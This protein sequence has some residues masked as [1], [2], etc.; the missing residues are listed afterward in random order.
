MPKIDRIVYGIIAI[1]LAI[2]GQN[3]LEKDLLFDAIL[4][5]G[6]G[7]ILLVTPYFWT[8][9]PELSLDLADAEEER[10]LGLPNWSKSWW[11]RLLLLSV[12]A[13][14][15]AACLW[16]LLE[17]NRDFYRPAEHAWPLY[18][19][20]L[21]ILLL[22]AALMD[23]APYALW[24]LTNSY[25]RQPAFYE[26]KSV[27]FTPM[28][29]M[30]R[31]LRLI[32]ALASAVGY[33]LGFWRL[34]IVPPETADRLSDPDDFV[35]VDDNESVRV[36]S[37]PVHN[38]PW[39]KR[40]S[41]FF[42]LTLAVAMFMRLYLL[43]EWP[44]GT[45][46]DEAAAGLMGLRMV[47]DPTWQPV[48]PGSINI[49]A[50]YTYLIAKSVELFGPT[51]TAVRMVSVI[52]GLLA[53]PAAYMAGRELF[54]RSVGLL[55]MF[56]MATSRW[57]VNFSRIGMYNIATP[58]FE[59]LSL[60]YML[61]ALRRNRYLDFAL[62]GLFVGLGLSFYPAFQLF[63]GALGL[64]LLYQ[65]IATRGFLVRYWSG[66]LVMT[67]MAVMVLSPLG[68]FAYQ[69]SDVYF[70][71]TKETSL[72][73]TTQPGERVSALIENTRK[74]LLMF[75][76]RGDPNGRHNL[77][78]KPMMDPYTGALMVLGLIVTLRWFWRPRTFFLLAWLGC[79]LLG[80]ILSLD[81]EAPQ[82][83]RS[84]ATLPAVYLL[85]TLP[86][87]LLWR[88]WTQSVDPYFSNTFVWFSGLL[89]IPVALT[90]G[91]TYFVDQRTDF[92]VWNAYSTPETLTAELLRS[93]DED[94]DAYVI[95][96]F[97]G[98]PTINYLAQTKQQ[99]HRVE[100]TDHLPLDWA[101]GRDALLV[102]NAESRSLYEQARHYYPNAEFEEIKPPF[103]GPTVLYR[104]HLRQSDIESIQGLN[105]FY[106]DNE[107][108]TGT[109]VHTQRDSQ[110]SF[111]WQSEPPLAGP[112]S[113]EWQGVLRV[114]H[115]GP[116]Q[117]FLQAPAEAE[118]YVGEKLI[119]SLNDSEAD[120]RETA[121]ED[122]SDGEDDEQAQ[123]NASGA[124]LTLAEGNHSIRLRV[125]GAPG[126]LNFAWR[127]PDR[128]YELVPSRSLY[129]QP[130]SSNGLLGEYYANG[131]WE[132]APTL[133]RIDA[134][135]E[136][137]FH[138][139]PLPRP[140]TVQWR[141]KI[142]I[143]QAGRYSFG[144]ESIDESVLTID[145]QEVVSAQERNHYVEG[146][147]EL[148]M[149]LHDISIRYADRTD[150][151]H[152]NLH[153][154]QPGGVREIVP[155][156]FLFPPQASYERVALP[157]AG[158][159]RFDP[160]QPNGVSVVTPV[161]PNQPQPMF[162]GFE[163]PVGI[164][165]N[166]DGTLFVS[167]VRNRRVLVYSASG[168]ALDPILGVP[169]SRTANNGE[170][171][172]D[173]E[174]FG[175]PF[176]LAHDSQGRLLVLD[177]GTSQISLFDG[178]GESVGEYISTL[179]I[180]PNL[181]IRS[182]GLHVDQQD[183]VWVPLTPRGRVAAFTLEG[184][185]LI[186]FPV[187]PGENSQPVDVAVSDQGDIWVVDS[188]LHKL[189]RFD[190]EGQRQLAWDIAEAN[191]LHGPHLA[192]DRAGILYMTEPEAE[193]IVKIDPSGERL[194][195]WQL[196]P[197]IEDVAKPI[198]IDIDQN[199]ELWYVDYVNQFAATMG[200][201]SD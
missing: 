71:R 41:V 187:W 16:A 88:E 147:I 18:G 114:E 116:H 184:E 15:I 117:F 85:A 169:R 26:P 99:F 113:V 176:D 165:V 100:T 84:I 10:W 198:G 1:L 106:Y 62:A 102:T 80:G 30:I 168:A 42:L 7:I 65:S 29:L 123:S 35:D 24:W 23:G 6:G 22:A 91:W 153:W 93:L 61:M 82:S 103:G 130:V 14:G 140:Y 95:S 197:R 54:G 193:R 134:K 52:M 46:Y 146:Q 60:A 127:P 199:G 126:Q 73:S 172:G 143:P 129:V 179:P 78:S 108:W 38:L 70:A 156:E 142:A 120:E 166:A 191:T 139:T 27:P 66:L 55:F 182:R 151:T 47:E 188:G 9:L 148:D 77:P 135:F 112:Y 12:Y 96:Y 161:L 105:G 201:V 101:P 20:G 136:L 192:I 90:N 163:E 152:I 63:V 138:V 175:E 159:L 109:F 45:W 128:S 21:L 196:A 87:Y 177:V 40:H 74:H 36:D 57:H 107:N 3:R 137:Y 125:K 69:E 13:V 32:R 75:N 98:H 64:Y 132:G 37:R 194:G 28:R 173:L 31:I 195:E 67:V 58:L 154:Q 92:A 19:F 76:Y 110:I 124:E 118:L 86:I 33:L 190:S 174:R 183:R 157:S 56:F 189:I 121:S 50:H 81:F 104:A 51:T 72:L 49:T 122:E 17:F 48:F 97:H 144:L 200:V 133:A 186:D 115:F 145:G 94:T 158:L 25:L 59:L 11:W 164:A 167:D 170:N 44:F 68:L 53:V 43:D 119:L 180:D 178:A 2:I 162:R 4:F 5:Y 160:D 150:H 111:D 171:D 149:G 141:G 89:L 131:N 8:R 181:L 155:S 83:L 34:G 79:G 39:S 185:T